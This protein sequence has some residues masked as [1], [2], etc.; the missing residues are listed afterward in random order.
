MTH[1]EHDI[2]WTAKSPLE[3]LQG[4]PDTIESVN[5]LRKFLTTSF[6][7][8]H[9]SHYQS[10][11]KWSTRCLEKCVLQFTKLVTSRGWMVKFFL[12]PES[13]FKTKRK[14][15]AKRFR[16]FTILE[17]I[18][19]NAVR[20]DIPH[21]KKIHPV[22]HVEHTRPAIKQPS[23]IHNKS[24]K[25]HVATLPDC[26]DHL[27]E[28]E[29]II[30]HKLNSSEQSWL[31]LEKGKPRHKAQWKPTTDFVNPDRTA[32]EAYHTYITRHELLKHLH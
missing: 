24:L 12:D 17:L 21:T 28:F 3:L 18:G 30:Q 23:D 15:S 29:E 19:C 6:S 25:N 7:D 14:L 26:D 2:G 8:A 16:S 13:D 20:L 22:V 32:T 4:R 10:Q 5:Y 1:F 9:F 11:L 31:T 27:I